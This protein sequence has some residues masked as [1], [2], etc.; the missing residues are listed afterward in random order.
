MYE[1]LQL[2]P[3]QSMQLAQW[4]NNHKL[5]VIPNTYESAEAAA[6]AWLAGSLWGNPIAMSKNNIHVYGVYLGD[7]S[8]VTVQ[9]L[10]KHI[11]VVKQPKK[12]TP[13]PPISEDK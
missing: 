9:F 11:V 1:N 12:R 10:P 13:T 3:A 4:V 8:M 7:W 6:N 2:T 5:R